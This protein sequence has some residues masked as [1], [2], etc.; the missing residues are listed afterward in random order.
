MPPT[1]KTSITL[2]PSAE[3]VLKWNPNMDN[4]SARISEIITRYGMLLR[5]HRNEYIDT[6]IENDFVRLVVLEWG[7]VYP[8]PSIRLRDILG[9]AVN[10]RLD[11]RQGLPSKE[12]VNE[13]FEHAAQLTPIDE[14]VIVEAIEASSHLH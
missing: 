4:K 5:A 13:L 14:M 9:L 11:N 1:A 8:I 3:A 12:E 7:K 10:E 2:S 6:F